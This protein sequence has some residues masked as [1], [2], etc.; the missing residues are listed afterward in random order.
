MDKRIKNNT[1]M[2]VQSKLNNRFLKLLFLVVL[3]SL[4][5]FIGFSANCQIN[6]VAHNFDRATST[7]TISGSGTITQEGISNAVGDGTLTK[8]IIKDGITKIR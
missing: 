2:R 1:I 4:I 5:N 3:L 7:L 6:G 8:V